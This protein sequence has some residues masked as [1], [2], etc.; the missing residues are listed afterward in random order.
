MGRKIYGK[1]CAACHGQNGEGA[2]EWQEQN[3][4]G[5]LPPPP[6][7]PEGHTWRH[8]DAA[9]YH[10]IAKGWRDPFNETERLT[11]PAFQEILTPEKT[12]AVSTYLKTLWTEEQRQFQWEQSQGRPF[13][14]D[15]ED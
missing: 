4:Q 10:M 11:M 7:G 14:N 2:A 9:L 5:E 3:E 1:Y 12:R 6:H 15:I 13:P 8:A